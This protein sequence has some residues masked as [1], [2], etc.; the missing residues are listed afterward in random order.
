MVGDNG[1]FAAGNATLTVNAYAC[2]LSC[3][4]DSV[5]QS[6]RLSAKS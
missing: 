5:S 3:H 2:E 4:S 1:K 6:I